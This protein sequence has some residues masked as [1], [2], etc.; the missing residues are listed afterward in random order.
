MQ[1]LV[2][3]AIFVRALETKHRDH[4]LSL[5]AIRH[6][7]EK[8]EFKYPGGMCVP[9]WSAV[10]VANL[11]SRTPCQSATFVRNSIDILGDKK[12]CP[13]EAWDLL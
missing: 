8:G 6:L 2:D 10:A 1:V 5:E 12:L 3:T 7:K 9:G 13:L 4:Q 11:P